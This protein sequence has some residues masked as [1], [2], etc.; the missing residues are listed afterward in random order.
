MKE[1]CRTKERETNIK[2]VG[3]CSLEIKEKIV[4]NS[5][6]EAM[7]IVDADKFFREQNKEKYKYYSDFIDMKAK[8]TFSNKKVI[9][10]IIKCSHGYNHYGVRDTVMN[11]NLKGFKYPRCS[12]PEPRNIQYNAKR[13]NT[14][15]KIL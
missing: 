2:H 8:D 12:L 10:S 1:N 9:A 13:Q 3:K 7:R 15:E 11:K 14:L 4:T 5:V 6:K